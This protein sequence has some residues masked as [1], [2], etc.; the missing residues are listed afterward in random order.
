MEDIKGFEKFEQEKSK[1]IIFLLYSTM[2]YHYPPT[3][4]HQ[5]NKIAYITDSYLIPDENDPNCY[6][7]TCQKSFHTKQEYHGHLKD[8]HKIHLSRIP[9]RETMASVLDSYMIPDQND[10][11]F[12]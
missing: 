11:D 9:A 3:P 5:K 12:Y 1:K 2:V 7:C 6:C 4:Y 8:A 10:P